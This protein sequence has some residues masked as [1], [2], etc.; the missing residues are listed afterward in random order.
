MGRENSNS[1]SVL[2]LSMSWFEVSMTPNGKRKQQR[3]EN[4]CYKTM[5]VSGVS[6]TP[7]GKRKQTISTTA[8]D[9]C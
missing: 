6:M 7:K 4:Y 2:A 5:M 3:H 8:L 1:M 9:G